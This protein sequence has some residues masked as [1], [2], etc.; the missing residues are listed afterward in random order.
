VVN[1][2]ADFPRYQANLTQKIQSIRGMANGDGVI[3]RATTAIQDLRDQISGPKE[4]QQS[5]FQPQQARPSAP[6]TPPQSVSVEMR[7]PEAPPWTLYTDIITSLLGPLGAAALIA[8]FVVFILLYKEDLRDRFIRLA[9]SRDIQRSKLLLDE[10]AE[11]LSD[12]LLSQSAINA[13]FG[14]FVGASLWLIGMPNPALWGLSAT[15]L[16]FVPYFGIPIASLLP[17]VVALAIDPGWTVVLWTLAIFFG[18][19]FIVGQAIEP[20]LLGRNVGLSPVAVVVAATFWTW[21]WGP[22]GLLLAKQSV[23]KILGQAVRSGS[24]ITSVPQYTAPSGLAATRVQATCR[25]DKSH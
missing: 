17:I 25:R 20:W 7:Q 22:L 24:S 14:A 10:S 19:E 6:A 23:E 21:I 2:A 13:C 4:D 1:L 5:A 3:Q 16:R 18:S 11:R 12:Y 9:G 8:I 15:V